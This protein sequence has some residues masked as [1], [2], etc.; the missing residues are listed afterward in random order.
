MNN[1]IEPVELEE[2]ELFEHFKFEVPKGK[3]PLRLIN[4]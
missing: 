2:E 3:N 1:N 4:I